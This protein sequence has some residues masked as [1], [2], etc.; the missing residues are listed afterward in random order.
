ML[1]TRLLKRSLGF[2]IIPINV[3]SDRDNTKSRL[4]MSVGC[5]IINIL[6]ILINWAF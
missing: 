6:Y 1:S 5:Y 2:E 4:L 3:R